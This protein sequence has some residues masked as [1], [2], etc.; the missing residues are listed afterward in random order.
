MKTGVTRR[1]AD[2][3][4]VRDD[5]VGTSNGH[6]GSD[7]ERAG[8][9]EHYIRGKCGSRNNNPSHDGPKGLVAGMIICVVLGLA[10]VGLGGRIRL[11][12]GGGLL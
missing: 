7:S 2:V 5:G 12:R 9:C 3:V 1:G 11:R 4:G 6:A 8:A 10:G